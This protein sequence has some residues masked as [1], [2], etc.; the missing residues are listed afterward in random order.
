[1]ADNA[2]SNLIISVS[3]K[4]GKQTTFSY[5][6]ENFDVAFDNPKLF[7]KKVF[8]D[9]AVNPS[10]TVRGQSISEAGTITFK[11]QILI[12]TDEF[13]FENLTL[14]NAGTM[15]VEYG[16]DG[17][18]VIFHDVAIENRGISAIPTDT[19]TR[20]ITLSFLYMTDET[21]LSQ[22]ASIPTGT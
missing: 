12:P 6:I 8:T 11:S 3:A 13:N 2:A 21:A 1:M 9:P 15:R 10:G 16:E 19:A 20:N 7:K 22:P 17:Q 4:D 18:V 14:A 5:S